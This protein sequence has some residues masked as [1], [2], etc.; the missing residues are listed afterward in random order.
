MLCSMTA[1]TT[2]QFS[3]GFSGAY[4]FSASTWVILGKYLSLSIS[5]AKSNE[6]RAKFWRIKDAQN[7]QIDFSFLYFRLIYLS[8]KT[9]KKE[10]DHE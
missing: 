6:A 9:K 4:Y 8:H 7:H 1:K 10:N 3:R 5:I 2:I